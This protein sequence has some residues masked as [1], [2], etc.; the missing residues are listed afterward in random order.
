[1]VNVQE[2][3]KIFKIYRRPSERLKEALSFGRRRYHADFTAVDNVSL[4]IE[5]GETVGLIGQNGSGKSTLLKIM[6]RLM[7]PTRGS[8]EISGRVASLIELGTGFHPEFTGRSNIYLTSSLVGFSRDQIDR[9]VPQVLEF[10]GLEEFIDRPLKTYSSGMWVRLAF[11]VAISVD[12]DVFLIDEALAVGDMLFQQRCVAK[13]REFQER[14]VTV[15]F[16]SHDLGAVKTLCDRAVLLDRGKKV[17]EGPPEA[18]CSEYVALMADRASRERLETRLDA[19]H[20]RYGNYQ[21]EIDRVD[22]LNSKGEP[23]SAL[24][25][26]EKCGIEVS[27]VVHGTTDH[28]TVGVMIRDRLGND[29]FGTNTFIGGV[30]IDRDLQK[31][32]VR[33]E[34]DMDLGPGSYY[35]S[36]AVHSGRDHLGDCYDWIDNAVAFQILPTIPEF[37]GCARLKPRISVLPGGSTQRRRDAETQGSA[38]IKATGHGDAA[39][40][41][42]GEG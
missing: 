30:R 16:V 33:F 21:A 8:V 12:P 23:A 4:K 36:A 5:K 3:T 40:R 37:V 24:M 18:I 22:L 25:S 19:H 34:F 6:A 41:G 29:I 38:K 14:G 31:F 20:R 13:L 2:L 7:L 17:S 42:R 35:L 39:T 1:M 9:M 11:S 26:G 32:T 27:V 15:V 28:P 10:S